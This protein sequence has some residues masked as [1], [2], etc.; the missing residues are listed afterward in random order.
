M[1][2]EFLADLAQSLL[3]FDI[4][5]R[6]VRRP[7]A[8]RC[9]LFSISDMSTIPFV[10]EDAPFTPEQRLW[11]NRFFAANFSSAGTIAP[12]AGP[13]IPVT[14]LYASQTGN[15][16]GLAKK[17]V[18]DLKKGNFLPTL[19]DIARYDTAQ[20]VKEKHV[21]IITSTYGDGEPP[22]SA[23]AFH[24]WLHSDA[25]PSLAGVKFSVLSLGDSTYPDFC[26]CGI[27]FDKRFEALGAE[28]IY[29]RI[30]CDVDFDPG[31]KTWSQGVITVLAPG[32]T[33]AAAPAALE[34][35]EEGYS[36]TRPFPARLL[37]QR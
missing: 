7:R 29:P 28:R 33:S 3:E 13:A 19:T 35:E 25:A 10:P 34:Q 26:Q 23:T 20:L 22:D 11:L 14:V 24:Q 31:Y 17:L 15:A 4:V 16:E 27:E 2:C 6:R 21:L 18:K 37:L 30:D 36:K 8:R 12:S 5:M 1:K 9:R 32:G